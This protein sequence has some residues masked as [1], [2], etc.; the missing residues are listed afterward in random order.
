[1]LYILVAY[2]GL[3]II[4][5]IWISWK[6]QHVEQSNF[7]ETKHIHWAVYNSTIV[8][9]ILIPI[10]VTASSYSTKYIIYC[11]GV[12]IGV[13]FSL[14]ILMIPKI[15]AAYRHLEVWGCKNEGDWG[16]SDW[17]MLC[18]LLCEWN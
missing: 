7:N 1:M 2:K 12:I 13:S 16:G 14:G 17:I 15:V 11:C 8:G 4:P 6:T 9:V 10:I 5:A 3:M 18:H